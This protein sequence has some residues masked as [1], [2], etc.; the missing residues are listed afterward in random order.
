MSSSS[1]NLTQEIK[2]SAEVRT[3]KSR[4]YCA[5]VDVLSQILTLL[6]SWS[7][8]FMQRGWT[9]TNVMPEAL[10]KSYDSMYERALFTEENCDEEIDMVLDE[11]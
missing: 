5:K 8:T 11:T 6:Y 2:C 7:V 10:K 3:T 9:L 4:E 1:Q